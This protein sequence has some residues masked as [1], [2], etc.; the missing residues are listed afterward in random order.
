MASGESS[1]TLRIEARC[2]PPNEVFSNRASSRVRRSA[3]PTNSRPLPIGQLIALAWMPSTSSTSAISSSGLREGRS[4]LLMKVRTGMPRSLHTAN[5][6]RVWVSTP[7]AA[8]STM[9][10][11][12]AAVR[13][14]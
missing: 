8:S 10:A 11:Q 7:L 9:I 5:S 14:R 4:S 3:T 13:V 6:L 2:A 1:G 12:S